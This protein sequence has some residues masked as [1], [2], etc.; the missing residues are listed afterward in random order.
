MAPLCFVYDVDFINLAEDRELRV[1]DYLS[2]NPHCVLADH[3]YNVQGNQNDD[4][5][6]DDAAHLDDLKNMASA[7]GGVIKPEVHGLVFCSVLKFS[8]C[9]K[10]FASANGRVC[11]YQRRFQRER[12]WEQRE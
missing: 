2:K 4:R 3:T 5:A 12:V 6:K 7:R 1:E 11:Q 10:A 8:I 9:Y